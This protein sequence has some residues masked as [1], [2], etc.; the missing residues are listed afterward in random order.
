[1]EDIPINVLDIV[2]LVVIGLSAIVGLARGLVRETL[3]LGAWIGA[4]WLTLT[5]FPDIKAWTLGYIE[6]D[7][8]AGIVGG[9]GAFI[10]ILVVLMIIARVISKAVQNSQLIGPLDRTLGMLFGVVRGGVLVMLGYVFTLMMVE[11]DTKKP[12]WA[13]ES[14]LLPHVEQGADILLGII[15]ADIQLP[16]LE[17]ETAEDAEQPDDQGKS[18]ADTSDEI[19]YRPDDDIGK[20]IQENI[21]NQMAPEE[22]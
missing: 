2:I 19:G 18:D 8:W 6:S 11:E 17:E 15:P 20:L 21:L 12:L 22:E 4:G 5:F 13:V 14:R 3:S 9:I 10:G 1:M 16:E 7:L